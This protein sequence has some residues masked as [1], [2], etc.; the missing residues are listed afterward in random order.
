MATSGHPGARRRS[1]RRQ[2]Q[3]IHRLQLASRSTAD[4]VLFTLTPGSNPC[5]DIEG[6]RPS[7]VA[8]DVCVRQRQRLLLA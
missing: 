1:T 5:L 3:R 7:D 6:S 2:E 4:D 8:T